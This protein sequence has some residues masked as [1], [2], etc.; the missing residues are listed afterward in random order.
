M[1]KTLLCDEELILSYQSGDESAL[2]VLIDRHQK[3]VFTSIYI[4]VKDRALAED[5]F[6]DTFIKV[7]QALRKDFYVENGKFLG[8]VIRIAKNLALDHFRK[9]DRLP[10]IIDSDEQDVLHTLSFADESIE[11]SII[12]N[13]TENKVKLMIQ[14][15][16]DD[17]REV[18]IMRH[19]GQLSFKEIAELTNTNVNTALGR[20]RYALINLRKMLSVHAVTL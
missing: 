7:I 20:M 15:L 10:T 13:E 1:K 18:L 9:M 16:P 3:K 11:E 8:W 17:Q 19:Y 5:L 4:L 6:Q 14:Q 2:K 12:R